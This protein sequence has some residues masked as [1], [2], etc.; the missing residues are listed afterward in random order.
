MNKITQ[1]LATIIFNKKAGNL[2]KFISDLISNTAATHEQSLGKKDWRSATS[3]E[4][5]GQTHKG[6]R[7]LEGIGLHDL[8]DADSGNGPQTELMSPRKARRPREI[9]F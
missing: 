4:S 5:A 6:E 1:P 7:T 8:Q 9:H 3:G 2:L